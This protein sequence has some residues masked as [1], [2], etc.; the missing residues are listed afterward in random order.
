MTNRA[1][2]IILNNINSIYYRSYVNDHNNKHTP[3][4]ENPMNP[5][6]W[7]EKLPLDNI[8]SPAPG[9]LLPN[10]SIIITCREIP[11]S[12][13]KHY[14]VLAIRPNGEYVTWAYILGTGTICGKYTR[15]FSTAYQ[16]YLEKR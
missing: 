3:M 1:R 13:G 9:D 4:R 12:K 16:N 11:D 10:G 5:N 7:S 15:G 2:N 6:S 14:I 8:L